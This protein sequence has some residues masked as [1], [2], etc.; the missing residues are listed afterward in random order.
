MLDAHTPIGALQKIELRC[1][2]LNVPQAGRCGHG[3][4]LHGDIGGNAKAVL[5]AHFQG[6]EDREQAIFA[7]HDIRGANPGLGGCALRARDVHKARYRLYNGIEGWT[8]RE[9][10]TRAKV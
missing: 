4:I 3:G 9:D 2:R 8:S 6:A 1:G 5:I 10:G 7:A